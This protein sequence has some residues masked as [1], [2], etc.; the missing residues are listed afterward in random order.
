VI[1]PSEGLC[2]AVQQ[3]LTALGFGDIVVV[4]RYSSHGRH[5]SLTFQLRVN[6]GAHLD[7]IYRELERIDGVSYLF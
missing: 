1:G 7:T 2:D 3:V 5:V 4:E 6:S